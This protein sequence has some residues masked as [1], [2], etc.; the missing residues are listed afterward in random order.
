MIPPQR[1]VKTVENATGVLDAKSSEN[2]A[3]DANNALARITAIITKKILSKPRHDA[4]RI[5]PK[6]ERLLC[7]SADKLVSR[8]TGE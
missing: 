5:A 8:E 1:A 6:L 3:N 7:T 4:L 2:E